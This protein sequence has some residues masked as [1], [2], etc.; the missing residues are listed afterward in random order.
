LPS[1]SWSW[2]HE[3]RRRTGRRQRRD[4]RPDGGPAACAAESATGYDGGHQID[5]GSRVAADIMDGRPYRWRWGD[6]TMAHMT[7]LV[8]SARRKGTRELLLTGGLIVLY[9]SLRGT[10]RALGAIE[11]VMR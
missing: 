10:A 5:T 1:V 4:R 3:L 6:G 11:S 7:E 8:T 9:T 2:N